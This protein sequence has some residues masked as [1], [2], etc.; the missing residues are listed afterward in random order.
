LQILCKKLDIKFIDL[1]NEMK[2]MSKVT[3]INGPEDFG[4]YNVQGNEFIA[5]IINSNLN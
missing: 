3:L 4:H 5:K 2:I 1:T